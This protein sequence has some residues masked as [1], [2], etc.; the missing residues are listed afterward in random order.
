MA[1]NLGQYGRNLRMQHEIDIFDE[2]AP[3]AAKIDGWKEILKINIEYEAPLLMFY[4]VGDDRAI[5]LEP[6]R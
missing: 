6:V 5:S 1:R 3:D 2:K 4:G